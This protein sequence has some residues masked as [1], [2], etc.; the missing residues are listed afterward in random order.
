MSISLGKK[1]EM[2][3]G[4]LVKIILYAHSLNYGVRLR[5]IERDKKR[6]RWNATH[7]RTCKKTKAHA[8]HPKQHRFSSIGIVNS[9]HC[10]SLAID[11]YITIDDKIQ[12]TTAAYQKL[13][14]RW[15]SYHKLCC[16]GGDFYK[17]DGGHFSIAHQERK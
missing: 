14:T 7:C 9:I 16:W 1:Q 8:N 6:A 11:F 13:G 10:D 12:W 3:A 17:K 15:K 2:F 4:F 5:E